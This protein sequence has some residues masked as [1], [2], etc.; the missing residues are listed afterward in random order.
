[1]SLLNQAISPPDSARRA[2]TNNAVAVA[3]GLAVGW[4]EGEESWSPSP[5]A[6]PTLKSI[7]AILYTLRPQPPQT[8]LHPIV[9]REGPMPGLRLGTARIG[10][11]K[12]PKPPWFHQGRLW[13][14]APQSL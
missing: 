13:R 3:G 12:R 7:I 8:V 1:L 11:W 2:R 4:G 10:C 14:W 6:G 5:K 9:S